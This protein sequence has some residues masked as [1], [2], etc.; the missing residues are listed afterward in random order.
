VHTIARVLTGKGI[1]LAFV[2]A[3]VA[4][5]LL[6]LSALELGP[7][8]VLV[9]LAAIVA[10]VCIAYRP[11]LGFLALVATTGGL[12][13]ADKLPF[14]KVGPIS[15]QISDILLL[16]LLALTGM[17]LLGLPFFRAVRTPL[18]VPF[19][20]FSLAILISTALAL[21]EPSISM[22]WAL[23]R[24]RPLAYYLAYFPVTNLI[25][26][27]R[28]L[29]VIINGLIV[30][31]V[32][33]SVA[34][35]AQVIDPSLGLVRTRTAGLVTAGQDLG[36]VERTYF[37]A[38]RLIY[39]MLIVAASSLVLRGKEFRGA[40]MFVQV[41][42]LAVGLFLTF[43]RNYWLTAAAMLALLGVLASGAARFRVL[44]WASVGLIGLATLSSL[45][46]A[47]TQRY[48]AAAQD[49]LF[50]G[51]RLDVLE[52]DKSAQWRL[53]EMRY[54]VQSIEENPLVGIGIGNYYRPAI[55]SESS[56]ETDGLRY[57]VHN[58]YLWVLVDMGLVGFVPFLWL[59]A[60]AIVRG[61]KRWR[62]ISDAKLRAF[63]LGGTLGIL[64]QAISNLVAPNFVQSW[65]LVAFPI[66]LGANEL[67]YGWETSERDARVAVLAS[68][69]LVGSVEEDYGKRASLA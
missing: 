6:G 54:A 27:K 2:A 67:I 64:G 43:Q 32:L 57:Y 37:Q 13:G 39:L 23:R 9:G 20:W 16:Y 7:G 29:G 8:L 36:D 26:D 61:L 25:R 56:S 21:H 62:T 68:G 14:L 12:V 53:M 69:S 52:A 47:S 55:A 11:E 41:G 42:V 28:Q 3:V 66:V 33:A 60:A 58:A 10:L 38:E 49:R 22:N 48:L 5:L 34:V 30:L 35:L 19:L 15:L 51:M 59:F 44:K 4:G 31:A 17:K 40:V 50:R 45:P 46:L 24:M 1:Y 65:I 18:D 63:A